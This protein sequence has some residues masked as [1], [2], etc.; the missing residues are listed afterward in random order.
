MKWLLKTFL[1]EKYIELSWQK[2]KHATVYVNWN[3]I[4]IILQNFPKNYVSLIR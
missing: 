2:N 4:K 3:L 1:S